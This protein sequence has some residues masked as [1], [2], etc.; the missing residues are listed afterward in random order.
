[1][2]DLNAR[3]SA[4]VRDV[5]RDDPQVNDAFT[6][7]LILEEVASPNDNAYVLSTICKDNDFLVINNLKSDTTV[8]TF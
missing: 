2:E 7:P 1:M 5:L 6:Y 8:N 3:F 4:S